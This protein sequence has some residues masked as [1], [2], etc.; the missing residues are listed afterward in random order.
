MART[1]RI[2]VKIIGERVGAL[3]SV[4]SSKENASKAQNRLEYKPFLSQLIS[5]EI[6]L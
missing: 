3:L 4:C 2:R 6:L 5:Q 1:I